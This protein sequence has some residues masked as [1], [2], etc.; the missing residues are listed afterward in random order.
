MSEEQQQQQEEEKKREKK[1]KK[2]KKQDV[3]APLRR[4]RL[5]LP[6]LHPSKD[7]SEVCSDMFV[8]IKMLMMV[9]LV[10]RLRALRLLSFVDERQSLAAAARSY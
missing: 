10:R 6:L 2:E 1:R 4:P 8:C 7:A 3:A 9:Y 5:L